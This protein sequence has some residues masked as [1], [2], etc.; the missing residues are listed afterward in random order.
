MSTGKTLSDWTTWSGGSVKISLISAERRE[1]LDSRNKIA[2]DSVS[3]VCHHLPLENCLTNL[4]YLNR[5]QLSS[6]P[7]RKECGRIAFPCCS[8]NM[9]MGQLPLHLLKP[10]AAC[11]KTSDSVSRK[12]LSRHQD[13][14]SGTDAETVVGT[15]NSMPLEPAKRIEF[16]SSFIVISLGRCWS[17]ITVIIPHVL[18]PITYF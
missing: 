2:R 15:E 4:F 7:L 14:G 9:D 6:L 3:T 12:D 16:L 18:I 17:V 11:Q 10:V 1:N 13:V 8:R 5:L